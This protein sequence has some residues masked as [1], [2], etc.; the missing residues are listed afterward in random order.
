MMPPLT[1][2]FVR[3]RE[4]VRAMIK[5]FKNNEVR[6]TGV[7]NRGMFEQVKMLYLQNPAAGGELAVSLMEHVLTGDHSSD[8]FM[9]AFAIA[10]HQE[11]IAKNQARW[12]ATKEAKQVAVED[13][14]REIAELYNGGMK[15]VEIA[16]KLG[17]SA[18]NVSKKLSKIRKEFP[19][20]LEA[21]ISNDGNFVKDG[22]VSK[23]LENGNDGNFFGNDGNV[24]TISEEGNNFQVSE[25]SGNME[26][27][28]TFEATSVNSGNVSKISSFQNFQ[29]VYVNDN[30]N[31]NDNVTG[32]SS[33]SS[34][35]GCAPTPPIVK[36][37]FDF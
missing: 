30:V 17:M 29:H 13:S 16:R 10:N 24:S 7:I 36:P 23:L 5:E 27:M 33:I 35:Q 1:A 34:G 18:G 19:W 37:K 11:T 14:L 32:K 31:V 20:L 9:V 12:D 2:T 26:T 28:E 6:P 15:Q 22:N 25:I 8:D 4:A 3:L 21:E